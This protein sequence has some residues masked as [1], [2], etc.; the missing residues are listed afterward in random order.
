M[1]SVRWLEGLLGGPPP[2]VAKRSVVAQWPRHSLPAALAP[3][4]D[5]LQADQRLNRGN[6]CQ[7]PSATTRRR[8][9]PQPTA[10]GASSVPSAAV[11]GLQRVTF[12][13]LSTALS[14]RRLLPPKLRCSALSKHASTLK[15][16]E[17]WVGLCVAWMS[18]QRIRGLPHLLSRSASLAQVLEALDLGASVGSSCI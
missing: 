6:S 13:N 16:L 17:A 15:F 10:D 14:W 5:E 12:L 3:Q 7:L 18:L 8:Q 1:T 11:F 9:L 4:L 2:V